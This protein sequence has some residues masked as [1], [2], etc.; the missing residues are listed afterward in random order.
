MEINHAKEVQERIHTEKRNRN[1]YET[2]Y[3]NMEGTRTLEAL[4]EMVEGQYCRE[5]S[6]KKKA[7][8]IVIA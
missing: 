2:Y 8:K 3:K 4:C 5:N 7:N 1:R 6:E